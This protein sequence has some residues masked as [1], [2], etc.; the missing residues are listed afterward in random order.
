M[1]GCF[2]IF[3]PSLLG[4]LLTCTLLAAAAP[5]RAAGETVTACFDEEDRSGYAYLDAGGA[6][7]GAAVDLVREMARQAGVRLVLQPLPWA[8]CLR[9][10]KAETGDT[11]DF[12]FYA[13]TNS[14]RL[15][16]YAF[17]GPIHHVTGGAW[18]VA[19]RTDLPH[20]LDSFETM[21]RYRLCGLAGSNYAWLKDVGM[22]RRIDAGAH[23]IKAA[24]TKLTLGRCDYLLGTGELR[25]SAERHGVSRATMDTLAFAAYP[26][27]SPVGHYLLFNK[28]RPRQQANFDAFA[29]AL[30]QL[31]RT[32]AVKRIYGE[33]GLAP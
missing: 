24:V 29:A 27:A 23:N 13:S 14:E 10:A 6:W 12:A 31:S 15:A 7:R 20:Q 19:A 18:L 5:A 32:G 2:L 22:D 11:V 16:D 1:A 26:K 21:G 3:K 25:S 4:S 28:Q 30:D 17:L 9:L 8:R 33:Y